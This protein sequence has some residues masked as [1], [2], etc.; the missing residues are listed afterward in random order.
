MRPQK[1]VAIQRLLLFAFLSL[2]PIR[3]LAQTSKTHPR[4][5]QAVDENRLTRLRSNTHPLA[6]PEF[7]RGP[8]SPT[9]PMERM[10]HVLKRSPEQE[11]ALK[12]RVCGAVSHRKYLHR[13]R[14]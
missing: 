1:T 5:M 8:A 13:S 9:L 6:R 3:A 2:A 4:I 14:R 10:L 7:D 11:A 12:T